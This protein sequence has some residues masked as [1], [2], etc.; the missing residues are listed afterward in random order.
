MTD[1]ER[2]EQVHDLLR[3]ADRLRVPGHRHTVETFL[4]EIGDL[5][6]GLR[7]LYRDLT[8]ADLPREAVP[9][10]SVAA[11]FQPGSIP[12]T[13]A[14]VAFRARPKALAARA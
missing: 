9:R 3:Q 7:R 5:R 11:S 14:T 10:R 6:L 13:L 4:G 12:G 1:R 2:A 8:G